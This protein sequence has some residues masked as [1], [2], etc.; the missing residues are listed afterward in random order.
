MYRPERN[1]RLKLAARPKINILRERREERSNFLLSFKPCQRAEDHFAQSVSPVLP[2][3]LCRFAKWKFLRST[4][5]NGG[6]EVGPGLSAV[7]AFT[8]E[9]SVS[10]W[11]LSSFVAALIRRRR[12]RWMER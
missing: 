8:P 7:G 3:A 2:N 5:G 6:V 1:Q 12:S 10:R 11:K 9:A 4:L